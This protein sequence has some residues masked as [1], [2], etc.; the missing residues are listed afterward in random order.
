MKHLPL[1]SILLL[2]AAIVMRGVAAGMHTDCT[3]LHFQMRVLEA[4]SKKNPDILDDTSL[5]GFL[6]VM[7]KWNKEAYSR[8]IRTMDNLHFSSAIPIVLGLLT[9]VFTLIKHQPVH[10]RF[11]LVFILS[12]IMLLYCSIVCFIMQV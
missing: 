3:K 5:K 8:S 6:P 1:L 10:P 12:F 7:I 4:I 9:G 11:R 2:F